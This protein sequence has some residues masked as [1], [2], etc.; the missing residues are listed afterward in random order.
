MSE[1]DIIINLLQKYISSIE[2]ISLKDGIL[3]LEVMSNIHRFELNVR[4]KQILMELNKLNIRI[5]IKDLKI[6]SKGQK[7]F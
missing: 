5:K 3:Y 4:K 6:I 1:Y 2:D 7:S